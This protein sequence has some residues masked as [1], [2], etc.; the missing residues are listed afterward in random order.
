MYNIINIVD[1]ILSGKILENI[2]AEKLFDIVIFETDKYILED[3]KKKKYTF[4][5]FFLDNNGYDFW[6]SSVLDILV[7]KKKKVLLILNKLNSFYILPFINKVNSLDNL[8]FTVVNLNVWI[9][10]KATKYIPDYNDVGLFLDY[11][12]DVYEPIDFLTF[13]EILKFKW[14]KYIRVSNKDY[15]INVF[16]WYDKDVSKDIINFIDWWISGDKWTIL[17]FGYTI[18]HVLQALDVLNGE[19]LFFDLFWII[20]YN[21]SF[22]E[23]V[24]NSL[25][26]TE[27]LIVIGDSAS[28]WFVNFLKGK[29]YDLNMCEVLIH[30]INPDYNKLQTTYLDYMFEQVWFDYLWLVKKIKKVLE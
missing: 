26:N 25:R 17:A 13:F 11:K 2:D 29:L 24:V 20:N 19:G 22:S 10:S 1:Y 15:P 16:E 21:F 9:V 23:E 30:V 28:N 7:E 4:K 18:P 6:L 14:K 3:F 8:D 5:L 12:I 27:N